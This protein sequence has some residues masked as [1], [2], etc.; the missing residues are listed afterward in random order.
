MALIPGITI[1]IPVRNRAEIVGR[2]LESVRNQTLR[3][4]RVVLVDNGST[5]ATAEVLRRWQRECGSDIHVTV[6]KEQTPG[7]AAARNRGL[8]EV[9]TEW[10]MFFDSDDVMAPRH[11]ER[12]LEASDGYDLVGWDV[13]Y[14]DSLTGNKSLKPFYCRDAQ[15]HNL[16]HGSMATQRYMAR[17]SLFVNSGCWNPSV[18]YWDDIELGA[19]ILH[20][21]PR[22]R[23][24]GGPATVDVITGAD[25]ITGTLYSLRTERAAHAL[26]CIMETLGCE[27]KLWIDVKHAIL[28]ADCSREGSPEGKAIIDRLLKSNPSMR[29]RMLLRLVYV[30]R[31]TGGRGIARIIR[32]LL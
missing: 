1:V 6:L 9:H 16:F 11:C 23:K 21:N 2:T 8:R 26:E 13:S 7:A 18:L 28:A 20:L 10:T 3:P 25:S 29:N 30:Y 32:P 12:A 31:R 5:D 17:T 24:I 27:R 15:Y 4:L 14:I 22:M 19:R